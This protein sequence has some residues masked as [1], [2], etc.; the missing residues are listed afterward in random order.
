MPYVAELKDRSHVALSIF[1]KVIIK[2]LCLESDD[3]FCIIQILYSGFP[4]QFIY[5]LR[6]VVEISRRYISHL[7]SEPHSLTVVRVLYVRPVL[8]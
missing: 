7:L 2:R 3:F 4:A 6:S 8:F 1:H 5:D